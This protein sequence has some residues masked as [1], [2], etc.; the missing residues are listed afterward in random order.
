MSFNK[1]FRGMFYN[2]SALVLLLWL[3]ALA[4]SPHANNNV[5]TPESFFGFRLGSD[6]K[7]AD[8][9]QIVDYFKVLDAASE[10]LQLQ[11]LGKTTEGNDLVVAI[12]SSADN[13]KQLAKWQKLQSRLADPRKIRAAELPALLAAARS[14]VL[15]NCSIHATE[16]GATQMAP[17]LAFDLITNESPEAQEIL[18]NVITLLMPCH[19]PDGQLLVVDWYRKNLGTAFEQADMPWLYHKYV[20]HDNNRDWF[21][22][23]QRETRLTVEKLHNV[24][25]PH[26]TIDMH[27][28]GRKGARL[29]VPPYIDPVEPNVDPI[30][31]S[32][33]NMLG[34]HVQGV[35]TAQGKTGVVSNAIFDAW[36]PARAYPHYH[37]GL[38]FLT[39]AAS[40]HLATPVMVAPETL[41]SG[42]GYDARKV[43][44]NFPAPWP[45]GLWTLRDIVDYDFA[46]ARTVL[47][48]AARHREFWL[49]SL[50]EVQRRACDSNRKPI[51][52][53]I[54]A[55]QRD[56]QGLLDLLNILQTGM[57]EIHRAEKIFRVQGAP[58]LAGDY[59]IRLDQP[60]GNFAKALLE[61]Q[62]YPHMLGSDGR[63]RTPY[64]MTAHTL[65]LYLG[66]EVF[67]AEQL[68]ADDLRVLENVEMKSRLTGSANSNVVALDRR[69]TASFRAVNALLRKDIPVF[70]APKDFLAADV[71][72][73]AGTFL[74]EGRGH[75]ETIKELLGKNNFDTR[76]HVAPIFVEFWSLPPDLKVERIPVKQAKIGLY[77]SWIANMDEGWTRWVLEENGFAY[78]NLWN[79]DI[80]AQDL[81]NSFEVIILPDQTASSIMNGHSA[82]EMPAEYAGGLEEIGLRNL[83]QFVESGGTLIAFNAACE[84]LLQHFWLQATDV[85]A[86]I[87]RS[88]F[89]APGSLLR[90]LANPNHP[91]AYGAQREEVIFFANSPAF[92]VHESE[93]VLTYPPR[94]LLLSG[95]LHG[96]DYLRERAALVEAPLGKGRVILFGFRPQFRAQTRTT[97]KFFF[98]ALFASD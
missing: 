80:R 98:N 42:L 16:V 95:W 17:E 25:H 27:Q 97:Y 72:W 93:S 88:T 76:E 90:V 15:I 53:V 22:F 91:L 47:Q 38:R 39:E 31:V 28:M 2:A 4:D 10:R 23:T 68:P 78:K 86:G 85:T 40:A 12:I 77:K 70:T 19:N 81:R 36:T 56:P 37:G 61:A 7:L 13:L 34:T 46:A 67:A 79:A 9:H 83:R 64:D 73:P 44:W 71:V 65:P 24:W 54:P 89:N 29:F 41:G 33:L 74:V 59:V 58:F 51:A 1:T 82:E 50:F 57:V 5:P 35:L 96:E 87:E 69:N 52:Y 32:L 63:S 92:R 8:Y 84:L 6:K 49:R 48:H 62:E 55:Q 20:G 43:S 21:M 66:V 26:I 30:I 94:N 45:G 18:H 3:P 14:V 75:I 11:N 60:Y